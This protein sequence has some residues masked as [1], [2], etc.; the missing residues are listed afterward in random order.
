M[1]Q[2]P[3]QVRSGMRLWRKNGD[4]VLVVGIFQSRGIGRAVLKNLNRARFGCIA[5]IHALAKR[6]P[7]I[8][9]CGVSAIGG[10]AAAAAVALA[11][12]AF[13]FWQ[14]G[15]LAD[16]RPGA[17]T[18]LL[19]AFALAGALSGWILVWL[20][21]QHVDEARLARCASTILPD[22][23]GVMAEVEAS[24]TARVLE[25]L[26]DVEA[27]A[28]VTFAFHSPP[29]FSAEST[30]RRLRE[31]RPS[32]QRL[33]ENAAHLAGSILISRDTQP[34]GQSFLRRLREVESALEWANASLTMSAEM[35]H[36]FTLSAEWLL[37]NAYLIREQV[38]DLRRRLPQKYYG[39]LPLIANGPK[40]GL[41]RVYH[42]AS[43]I[44]F[45]RGGALEPA[46]IRNFLVA[47]QA[48]PPLDI[49]VL[50]AL[51]LL[52]RLHLLECL[53]ALAIQVEQQQSQSEEAHF[54]A[55]RLI[56]A[57]RHS[58]TELLNDG[59]L[60]GAS[61]RADRAFCERTYG[62]SL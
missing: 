42:V 20:L 13:I 6:R 22:E 21:H 36:A 33:S 28:P 53:R 31:Q 29:P 37:D 24:E 47:F 11:I 1:P 16:Y 45:E 9:E 55:N 59:G 27:E 56:T 23:T 15:I 18:M 39:E 57:A 50:R 58:S 3:A 61:S 17:L 25:I 48:L 19:A 12:G 30:T 54:W 38:I 46:I 10:A 2:L 41:P 34:R 51:P 4:R 14:R 7:R 49:G 35:H 40:A 5:A 62:A 44:V 8:E 43:E 52:V 32:I 26:R 60:G